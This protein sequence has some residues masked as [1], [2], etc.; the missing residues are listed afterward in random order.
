MIR[1][2]Y[3][4]NFLSFCAVCGRFL[5]Y[6]CRKLLKTQVEYMIPQ[7]FIACSYSSLESIHFSSNPTACDSAEIQFFQGQTAVQQLMS[8]FLAHDKAM[9]GFDQ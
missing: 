5:H 7:L 9:K 2:G 1:M 3:P 4:Q 6:V 8:W